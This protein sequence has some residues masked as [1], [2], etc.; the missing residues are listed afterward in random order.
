MATLEVHDSRGRVE[1]VKIAREQM[2]LFGSDPKCDIVLPDPQVLPFHGRIRWKNDDYRIEAFPDA[3][4]IVVN[5][6]KVVATRFRQGDEVRVGSSRIFL[7]SSDAPL[8]E[9]EKTRIQA[10]PP[11]GRPA[12][13]AGAGRGAWVRGAEAAPPAVEASATSQPVAAVP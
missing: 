8:A 12:V 13:A 4:F 2:A 9:D 6:K 10:P 7:I 1:F 11:A 5:G 3:R